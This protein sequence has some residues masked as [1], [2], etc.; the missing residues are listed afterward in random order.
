M[1]GARMGPNVKLLFAPD[2]I[3][4]FSIV[5]LAVKKTMNR[6]GNWSAD[7]LGDMASRNGSPSATP[8]SPRRSARLLKRFFRTQGSFRITL[9]LLRRPC[10]DIGKHPFA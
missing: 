8:P 5:P 1:S 7:A 10:V 4:L 2:G 9:H 6:L 3:Q